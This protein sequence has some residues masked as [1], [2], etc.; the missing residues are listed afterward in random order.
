MK[1]IM[2]SL[3]LG[4]AALAPATFLWSGPV[5]HVAV[6]G[7]DAW[8]GIRATPNAARTDGPFAT[9]ARARDEVRAKK[10]TSD[11]PQGATVYV[12]G[13]VYRLSEPLVLGPADSGRPGSPIVYAAAP[14]EK[15]RLRGSVV[16]KGWQPLRGRIWQTTVP[17]ELRA[18]QFWQLFYRG[19]RQVLARTPNVDPQH[20]RSGGFSYA[21]GEEEKG[22]PDALT[23]DP[24]HLD[25]ARWSRPTEG[26]VHVWPWRN[27]NHD[28]CPIKSIDLEH[29]VIALAQPARYMVIKGN[30]FFLDNLREE[31]D[32]P[33]EWYFDRST[34]QLYFWP[35]DETDPADG[36]TVPV[37]DQLIS[38]QGDPAAGPAVHDVQFRGLDLAETNGS[39]LLLGHTAGCSVTASTFTDCG[40]TALRIFDGG[41]HNRVAGCD[42]SHVGGPAI[43][44]DDTIDW[45]H[46]PEGHLAY[47]V[48]DNNLVHDVGEVGDAWGAIGLWP[49]SGGNASHDN[50]ISHNLVHDTPR[51]GISFNGMG[52]IVEYNHVHHT[53]QEQS[54]TGAIG[55]GSRDIHER[56]S[57]IRYNWIHDTGGY[58]MLRPG[59]WEYP[60]Y[61]WGIY[62]DDYTSGVHVHGNLV[63]NTYR[64]GVMVHGGQDNLI[65]NNVFVEGAAQQLQYSFID[66]LTRGRTPAH[67]DK[68]EWLMTGTRCVG[69]VFW[70]SGAE[71]NWIKGAKW[72]QVLAESDRNVIWH[73]GRPVTISRPNTTEVDTWAD[74]QKLGYD[75]HSV[76]ADPQFVDAKRGDYRLRPDSPA[77]KLGFKPLPYERMGLY[78]SAERA[79]W[80]VADDPWREEHLLH[81]VDAGRP[82]TLSP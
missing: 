44:L 32:A 42:F 69:N 63:V 64:G 20:P 76:I 40:G 1:G 81:P 10:A 75:H 33:G 72:P 41:H 58:N 3:L 24:A 73:E 8:T 61:C 67:P 4:L 68:G 82:T 25:P 43:S 52:N 47:N 65:E 19:Q 23:Y 9:L 80:P 38:V 7:N 2:R 22:S 46:R 27:W 11:L 12:H 28:I 6:D 49:N 35:P 56:G 34:G 74:W 77:L 55:M 13:G 29:H 45:T 66:S 57:I 30:R 15:V 54:D 51:Q 17:A 62:L 5:V 18:V 14:G 26:R 60:H 31:L 70:Y 53:N 59:V 79:T 16:L 36:V 78:P 39:L 71:S 50:V 37:L 21:G 48:I